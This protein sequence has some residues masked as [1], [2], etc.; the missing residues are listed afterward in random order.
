MNRLGIWSRL[1]HHLTA[2]LR[3]AAFIV[4]GILAWAGVGS[5]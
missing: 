2:A 4:F 1:G 3:C 5:P